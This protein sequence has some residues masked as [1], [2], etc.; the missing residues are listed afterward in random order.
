MQRGFVD[1]L[2]T[3][4]YQG[5]EDRENIA[6]KTAEYLVFA[7]NCLGAPA[8]SIIDQPAPFISAL[9]GRAG[10]FAAS[11]SLP[12]SFPLMGQ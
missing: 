8:E 5:P 11:V 7:G 2:F 12:A 9:K 1:L 6:V 4:C 3:A 10:F